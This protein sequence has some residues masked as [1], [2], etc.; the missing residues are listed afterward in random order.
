MNTGKAQNE[1]NDLKN[2]VI[3]I[4]KSSK[5]APFELI[6]GKNTNSIDTIHITNF[7]AIQK[8][9]HIP[10]HIGKVVFFEGGKNMNDMLNE[11]FEWAEFMETNF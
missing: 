8:S 2:Q 6:V 11:P 3:G 1:L 9:F 5:D 10:N 7:G 4:F